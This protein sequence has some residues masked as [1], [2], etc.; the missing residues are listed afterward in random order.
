MALASRHK[1][2][3]KKG[4]VTELKL[5]ETI[6]R[7][8]CDTWKL[9]VVKTPRGKASSTNAR[10]QSSSPAK[11]PKLDDF[12]SEHIPYDSDFGQ[13]EEKRQ[14]LVFHLIP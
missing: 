1:K 9:E 8:G 11:R 13:R 12:D 10:V 3:K 6:S 14:T 7:N 5:V 4:T 2:V